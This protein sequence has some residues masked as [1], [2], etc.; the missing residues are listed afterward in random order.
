LSPPSWKC[1]LRFVSLVCPRCF[2]AENY[3]RGVAPHASYRGEKQQ[4]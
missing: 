1:L 3:T 4:H 2:T